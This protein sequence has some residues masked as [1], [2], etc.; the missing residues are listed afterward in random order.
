MIF[1]QPD[2]AA[3]QDLPST[4][5][6]SIRSTRR[7]RLH[8]CRVHAARNGDAVHRYYDPA[9]GQFLSMDPLDAVTNQP[10]SYVN[11]DPANVTDPSG[12]SAKKCST[13]DLFCL[14]VGGNHTHVTGISATLNI[15]AGVPNAADYFVGTSI[16]V[17]VECPV[18]GM[19]GNFSQTYIGIDTF[20]G[21]Q[22]M[23]NPA[24]WTAVDPLPGGGATLPN[25]TIINAYL[26][27]DSGQILEKESVTVRANPALW[28]FWQ[29]LT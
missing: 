2:E 21:D 27:S 5:V 15:P 8:R 24:S 7:R 17:E 9:T 11:N 6:A 16:L 4:A 22:A 13:T 28:G 23:Q 20:T 26:V 19:P 14:D 12:Q 29:W 1:A 18:R 10:Y 3:G 25:D